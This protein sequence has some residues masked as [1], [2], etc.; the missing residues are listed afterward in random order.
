MPYGPVATSYA[1]GKPRLRLSAQT[2]SVETFEAGFGDAVKILK[3]SINAAKTAGFPWAEEPLRLTPQQRL[4][5]LVALSRA[6]ALA[7]EAESDDGND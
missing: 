1:K 5:E 6:K 3:E 4:V 7:D 2:E